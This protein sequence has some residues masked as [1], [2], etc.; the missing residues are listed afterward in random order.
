MCIRD[1]AIPAG[2]LAATLPKGE[3]RRLYSWKPSAI[4]PSRTRGGNQSRA[5]EPASGS[6]HD[7]LVQMVRQ[8]EEISSEEGIDG[9]EFSEL[10]ESLA[11]S[12]PWKSS[13]P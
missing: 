6:S 2:G 4:L 8:E 9:H 12:G 11:A 7:L 1:S 3:A 10:S 13:E 5:E